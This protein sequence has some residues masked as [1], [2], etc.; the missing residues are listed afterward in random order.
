MARA[1]LAYHERVADLLHS[2]ATQRLSELD[3][4]GRQT[5]RTKIENPQNGVTLSEDIFH[6][7]WTSCL[8]RLY[9][10]R[11]NNWI[12]LR[13]SDGSLGEVHLEMI[14]R[15][16]HGAANL[17]SEQV[18]TVYTSSDPMMLFEL[19]V[20]STTSG[21]PHLSPYSWRITPAK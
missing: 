2:D 18:V 7:F 20:F 11:S 17:V 4:T 9:R 13:M 16:L 6:L 5:K 10:Q 15:K 8:F 1:S 12:D 14:E 21:G 3:A 19:P